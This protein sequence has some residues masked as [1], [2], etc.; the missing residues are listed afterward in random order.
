MGVWKE[1]CSVSG[2][3]SNYDPHLAEYYTHYCIFCNNKIILLAN[4]SLDSNY[5]QTIS[6]PRCKQ[7][8]LQADFQDH[9]REIKSLD[10]KKR[11]LISNEVYHNFQDPRIITSADMKYFREL[12]DKDPLIKV[13]LLLKYLYKING[14]NKF[15]FDSGD[16]NL[17]NIQPNLYICG[18]N[19]IPSIIT[20]L[21]N[22]NYIIRKTYLDGSYSITITMKGAEYASRENQI[23]P[24]KNQAFVAMWFDESLDEIFKIIKITIDSYGIRPLRIDEKIHDNKIDEEIIKEIKQ[25]RFLLADLTGHRG[26]VYYEIGYAHA[27]NIP[28]I[29]TGEKGTKPHFDIQQQHCTFW[30]KDKLDEFKEKLSVHIKE[31]LSK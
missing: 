11:L 17:F 21:S 23:Y 2:M 9:F 25:S 15:D 4:T 27:L 12:K 16:Q 18:N 19:E 13:N 22:E 8:I 6:C 14:I 5:Y 29:F 28:T 3:F 20:L 31:T 24:K 26:G 30:T 10:E 1:K 7:Y